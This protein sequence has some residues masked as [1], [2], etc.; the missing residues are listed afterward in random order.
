MINKDNNIFAKILANRLLPYPPMLVHANQA[1]FILGRSTQINLCCLF[2]VIA[3]TNPDSSAVSTLDAEEAFDS[4]A[5]PFMF[6]VLNKVRFGPFFVNMVTLLY[7]CPRATV[8]TND[9]ISPIFFL[10]NGTRQGC[11]LSPL[12][13]DLCMEPL[14]DLLRTNLAGRGIRVAGLIL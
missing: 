12:L 2:N 13:F 7:T 1:G 8:S 6:R 11:P 9:N 10:R 14:S 5:W 3:A 4:V